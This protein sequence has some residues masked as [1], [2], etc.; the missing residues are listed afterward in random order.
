MGCAVT[1]CGRLSRDME[2]SLTNSYFIVCKYSPS[3]FKSPDG[4]LYEPGR[5]TNSSCPSSA[6][7]CVPYD[8]EVKL[9]NNQLYLYC[10]KIPNILL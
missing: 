8:G 10:G 7:M 1:R 9:S 3:Y 4:S 6:D 2:L 5:C